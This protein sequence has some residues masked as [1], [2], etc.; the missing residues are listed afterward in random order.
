MD[1]GENVANELGDV[2]IKINEKGSMNGSSEIPTRKWKLFVSLPPLKTT[3]NK[4]N[5]LSKQAY[6]GNFINGLQ[7]EIKC[8]IMSNDLQELI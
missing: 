7:E 6:L 4:L 1:E 5:M 3:S 8:H 2:A